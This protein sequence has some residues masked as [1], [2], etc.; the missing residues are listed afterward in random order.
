MSTKKVQVICDR[1][2]AKT[3]ACMF[4]KGSNE[5]TK[6]P[7]KGISLPYSPAGRCPHQIIGKSD[8]N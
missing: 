7:G 6:V 2:G 3:Y 5:C 1:L 4:L 8:V